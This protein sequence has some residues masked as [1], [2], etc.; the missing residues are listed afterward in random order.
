[1]T[2]EL[3]GSQAVDEVGDAFARSIQKLIDKLFGMKFAPGVNIKPKAKKAVVIALLTNRAW[4]E[5][6]Y[7]NKDK[8]S[9]QAISDLQ[10]LSDELAAAKDDKEIKRIEG[11]LTA[12][13]EKVEFLQPSGPFLR[14]RM[15]HQV[16][17]D[18][19]SS[20]PWLN[21]ANW[22]LIE[23]MLPTSYIN[24]IYGQPDPN[25]PDSDDVYSVF[26][27]TH[28]LN[29]GSGGGDE[30]NFTLFQK[31]NAYSAYGFDSKDAFDK[32]CM[33]KIW[34]AWDKVTR[35]LEMYADNDWKWPIW[36]WDDPYQSAGLL[37]TD[38][39]VVP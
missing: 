13:D 24:A 27:P 26:E 20:D 10:K 5:V 3:V 6:G 9:E 33:T 23:D 28:V 11:A 38:T 39:A 4:F 17:I 14:L 32:A 29:G 12:L 15:P 31:D 37:S 8:S 22:V 35:R 1:M 19:N 21:D 30:E 25:N 7:T 36:V 16:L 34:Y 18:P 2:N